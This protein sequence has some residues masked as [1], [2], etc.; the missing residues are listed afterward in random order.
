MYRIISSLLS[1][2]WS[3]R[4]KVINGRV[5]LAQSILAY[6]SYIVNGVHV[7]G[8]TCNRKAQYRE[9]KEKKIKHH[10]VPPYL[11]VKAKL[12]NFNKKYQ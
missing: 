12:N 4:L 7:Y 8:P 10:R 5:V 9:D 1:R 3:T 2:W 11:T 6:H